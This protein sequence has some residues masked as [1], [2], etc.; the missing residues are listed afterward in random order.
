LLAF[1]LSG[2]FGGD[3]SSAFSRRYTSGVALEDKVSAASANYAK[4]QKHG[5]SAQRQEQS[6]SHE[7]SAAIDHTLELGENGTCGNQESNLANGFLGRS[8]RLGISLISL[9]L[10]LLLLFPS[11]PLRTT[12]SSRL[13]QRRAHL[14]PS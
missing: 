2:C 6:P 9:L 5:P 8:A 12:N 13:C 7:A 1:L 4:A 3:G 10:L 11:P 14:L